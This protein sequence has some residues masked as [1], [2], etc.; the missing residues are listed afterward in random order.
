MKQTYEIAKILTSKERKQ[1]LSL[2]E[3]CVTLD[4]HQDYNLF[5][6]A[7][8]L[9]HPKHL[10]MYTNKYSPL[11][12][13]GLDKLHAAAKEREV[14]DPVA[15]YF[16]DYTKDAFT[17]FHTDDDARVG[18]TMVTLLDEQDLSGG[19]TIL[20]QVYE[21]KPRPEHKYAKRDGKDGPYGQRIIP[22]VVPMEVGETIIYDRNLMHGVGL[23]REG[24]R[25]V[26]VTWYHT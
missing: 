26:L 5:D 11:A 2:K 24:I 22:E 8:T 3:S 14:G 10:G 16:L 25:T 17:K 21:A 7:K 23:V 18:L 1:L 9:I 6:I 13:Q 4:A 12:K 19:E 15:Q 20:Q